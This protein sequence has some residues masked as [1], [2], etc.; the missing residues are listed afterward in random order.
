MPV[1]HQ[2]TN[3]SCF[4]KKRTS[5]TEKRRLYYME[6]KVVG[7]D[8][9]VDM[10]AQAGC[11]LGVVNKGWDHSCCLAPPIFKGGQR[12]EILVEEALRRYQSDG[13]WGVKWQEEQGNDFKKEK[14]CH[15]AKAAW[16]LK[17]KYSVHSRN[18]KRAWR[19]KKE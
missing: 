5:R 19:L 14:V 16:W 12:K 4:I 3:I 13:L 11:V 2:G 17:K 8:K 18:G 7:V 6:D 10:I 9:E 1:R 15:N